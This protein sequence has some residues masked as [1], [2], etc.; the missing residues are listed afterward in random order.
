MNPKKGGAYYNRAMIY[1]G[2]NEKEA[3]IKD[4]STALNYDPG[5]ELKAL[6]NRAVLYLETE[7]FA[8][9]KNDLDKLISIDSWNHMYYYNRAYSKLQLNDIKGAIDDY[10]TVLKLNPDD[11]ATKKQLQILL[12]NQMVENKK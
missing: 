11:Q 12:D 7:K 2:L 5:L 4:Y 9:A 10:R 3:A 1:D 6:S 8:E